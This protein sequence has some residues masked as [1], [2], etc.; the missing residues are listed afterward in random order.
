MV[1]L[2]RRAAFTLIELLVVIAI[3][4]ALIGLLLP[5]VQKV[6]E[7]AA[8]TK[9]QNNLKQLALAAHNFHDNY[10]FLPFARGGGALRQSTWAALVLPFIEQGPLWSLFTNPSINGSTYAMETQGAL[11]Q[12]TLHHLARDQFKATGALKTQVPVFICPARRPQAT[13]SDTLDGSGNINPTTG[14]YTE[15]ITSDYAVNLG[16]GITTEERDKG[17]FLFSDSTRGLAFDKFSDGLSNTFLFGEKQV[18][19]GQ[20]GKGWSDFTVYSGRKAASSGRHA[21]P[22]FPLALGPNDPVPGETGPFGS[23][24]TGIVLFAF[25]DGRVQSLRVS[26]PVNVLGYLAD[27]N[28]GQVTGDY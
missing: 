16:S 21:G 5:A 12:V 11:P 14:A 13:I 10:Q 4:A 28:D 1:V 25:G 2:P 22:A 15:G 23:V 24:H 6:R 19:A 17:A 9:C 27:R 20:F 7:A 3:I 26:T 18:Q 8:R